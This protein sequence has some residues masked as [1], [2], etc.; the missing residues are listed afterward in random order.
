MYISIALVKHIKI[1]NKNEILISFGARL[2]GKMKNETQIL[3]IFLANILDTFI[4]IFHNA[5]RV[6]ITYH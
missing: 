5:Y 2:Y 4:K 3:I 6:V 1:S